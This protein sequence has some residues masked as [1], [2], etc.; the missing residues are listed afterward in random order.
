[1]ALGYLTAPSTDEGSWRRWSWAPHSGA[2]WEGEKQW[3]QVDMREVQ[4]EY[5]E[6]LAHEAGEQ[7][8]PSGCAVSILGGFQ[9]PTGPSPEQPGLTP[10][11]ALLWAGG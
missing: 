7:V 11:L 6:K 3:A 2:G 8:T 10:A 5:R 4:A 9:A 1:M